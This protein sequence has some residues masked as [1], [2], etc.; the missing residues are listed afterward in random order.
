[1][2]GQTRE[3]IDPTLTRA[4]DTYFIVVN[5]ENTKDKNRPQE[6]EWYYKCGLRSVVLLENAERWKAAA[7]LLEKMASTFG[8]KSGALSERAGKIRLKHHIW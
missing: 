4:L 1:L 8:P 5:L 6:W 3:K 7:N 2:L